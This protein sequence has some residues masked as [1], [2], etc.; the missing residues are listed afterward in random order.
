MVAGLH[1]GHLGVF[2]GT[3]CVYL[4]VPWY[5]APMV[6]IILAKKAP[7][8]E[9]WHMQVG[10]RG[11]FGAWRAKVLCESC[12]LLK[13]TYVMCFDALI[14]NRGLDRSETPYWRRYGT[15]RDFATEAV[16]PQPMVGDA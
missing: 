10:K 12:M 3:F 1:V 15:K 16:A 7:C 9:M 5:Q 8:V 6:S 4:D 14:T 2:F 13:V 11:I